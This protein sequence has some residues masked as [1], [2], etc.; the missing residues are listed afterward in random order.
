[1]DWISAVKIVGMLLTVVF[2]GFLLKELVKSAK[3]SNNGRISDKCE[4]D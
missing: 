4:L 3:E 2:L 1:M